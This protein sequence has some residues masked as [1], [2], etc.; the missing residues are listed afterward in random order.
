MS[1]SA[2]AAQGGVNPQAGAAAERASIARSDAPADGKVHI[3]FAPTSTA[4]NATPMDRIGS[5]LID[6]LRDF[7]KTRATQRD[8]M[9]TAQGGPASPVTVAKDELLSGPATVRPASGE[10]LSTQPAEAVGFDDAVT[11]MTRSFDYAIE[12][13]LIVK[14]G[15]QFS[16]SA[17]S[18]MRGQ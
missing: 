14:T 7:E 9:G 17:A 1:I 2:I 10:S 11:A 15:S 18:L 8:A 13:Q 16:S 5:S 3:S 6:T 12:T 4:A